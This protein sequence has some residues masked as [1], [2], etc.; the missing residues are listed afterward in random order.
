VLKWRLPGGLVEELIE[1][2][3]KTRLRKRITRRT[4]AK[5]R[6][7]ETVMERDNYQCQYCGNEAESLDHIIPLVQIEAMPMALANSL[8]NLCA[9]CAG[10]NQNKRALSVEDFFKTEYW[11]IMVAM[12]FVQPGF[13]KIY[14]RSIW[15]RH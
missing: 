8:D 15:W 2:L 11:R 1:P 10:C 4:R 12:N 14:P 6:K 7:Y 9:A 13:P 5:E 3:W